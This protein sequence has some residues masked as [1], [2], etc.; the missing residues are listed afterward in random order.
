MFRRWGRSV[1]RHATS[2]HMRLTDLR[3]GGALRCADAAAHQP[4]DF[5]PDHGATHHRHAKRSALCG[6]DHLL[7]YDQ[8]P[9]GRSDLLPDHGGAQRGAERCTDHGHSD[10]SGAHGRAHHGGANVRA[11]R[12]AD[13]GGTHGSL[14]GHTILPTAALPA[15]TVP[16]RQILSP[17][18]FRTDR[19][20]HRSLLSCR[21][22]RAHQL[23][24]RHLQRPAAG[25]K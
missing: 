12:G 1:A 19:L 16:G 4:A 10:H 23:L 11:V 2:A 24:C 18:S 13:H 14:P 22:R 20:P 5:C 7:A 15:H 6:T 8:F 3:D 17:G 25:D 21:V 9:N